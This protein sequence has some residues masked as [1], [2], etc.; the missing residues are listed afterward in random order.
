M[1]NSDIYIFR[2]TPY[3]ESSILYD[4]VVKEYG[5]ITFIHKGIK[6]NKRKNALQ[7]FCSYN[8]NWSGKSNI[9]FLRNIESINPIKNFK[10]NHK[11]IG[12]YY[13]EIMF[14]LTKNDYK[15]DKLYNHY[16]DC[17]RKLADSKYNY[18]ID[19]NI[20]EIGLLILTG[21]YI[22]FDHDLSGNLIK[23]D[24]R[25]AYIPEQGPKLETDY[26]E[27]Y[28]GSTLMAL[29]GEIEYDHETL[30]ESRVF[31]RRLINYYI[32]PKKIKTREILEYIML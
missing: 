14:Y 28:S 9:K 24:K 5:K 21:H 15:I 26:K 31:M 16:D 4:A 23:E 13:N 19:L 30:K 18:L 7:L 6:S 12:M 25:Y 10:D 2:V 8:I 20:F 3:R 29:A 22:F 17:L 11:I 1:E 32:Q 27:T